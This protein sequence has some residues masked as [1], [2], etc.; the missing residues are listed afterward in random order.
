MTGASWTAAIS[1]VLIY[2]HPFANRA[3]R[4][5]SSPNESTTVSSGAN[6]GGVI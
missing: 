4:E 2:K 6:H 1:Q 5:N 3:L